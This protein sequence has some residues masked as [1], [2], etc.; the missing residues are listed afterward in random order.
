[1]A[2]LGV[3]EANPLTKPIHC[4]HCIDVP[5]NVHQSIPAVAELLVF[6]QQLSRI[7]QSPLV[8]ANDLFD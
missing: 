3:M 1:M 8:V 2:D 4:W 6:M 5:F 7:I